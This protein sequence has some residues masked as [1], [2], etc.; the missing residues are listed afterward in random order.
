MKIYISLPISGIEFEQVY[1]STVFA[2]VALERKGHTAIDPLDVC[3]AV[4]DEMD[5]AAC[6]GRDIEAL[7]RCDAIVLLDG[8]KQSK[9]CQLE[10]KA[11]ELY[12]L[13]VFEGLNKVPESTALWH[14]FG[15]EED[16]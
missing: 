10:R 6:M 5:Y 16:V 15:K 4:G 13:Q 7:L 14:I 2:T 1:A 11:A 12:G 3:G 8:W 9:G